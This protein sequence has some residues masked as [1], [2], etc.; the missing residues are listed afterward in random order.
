MTE[1]QTDS[2][3]RLHIWLLVDCVHTIFFKM[4]GR[5]LPRSVDSVYL[6]E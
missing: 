6:N 1:T 2:V 5:L 4:D 3:Y